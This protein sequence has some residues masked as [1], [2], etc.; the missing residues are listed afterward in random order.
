MSQ[1]LTDRQRKA[2]QDAKAAIQANDLARAKIILKA[3]QHPKA[4]EW[5]DKI[6]EK[7]MFAA[8]DVTGKPK[9][10]EKVKPKSNGC[11]N[12]L[13]V[14][15]LV[16]VAIGLSGTALTPKGV[17][18]VTKA[19]SYLPYD[20]GVWAEIYGDQL[21]DVSATMRRSSS[22]AVVF[23]E[24]GKIIVQAAYISTSTGSKQ[25]DEVLVVLSNI[26]KI[27]NTTGMKIDA[28][29]LPLKRVNDTTIAMYEAQVSDV[30]AYMDGSLTG[31]ELIQRLV[32]IG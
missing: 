23:Q 24:D 19:T 9:E 8:L 18:S 25:N 27:A 26:S 31:N 7:E 30:Q 11:V 29:W 28:I 15:F 2:M 1:P 6:E 4:L 5:L 22:R 14:I 13:A 12:L 3:V 21:D 32:N 20:Q 17:G 16:V 10:V